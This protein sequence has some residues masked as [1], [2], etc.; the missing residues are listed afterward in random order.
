MNPTW[1]DI[2][3]IPYNKMWGS[4]HLWLPLLLEDRPFVVRADYG[5]VGDDDVLRKWWVGVKQGSG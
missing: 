4:D 2:P 5:K 1:F 3:D